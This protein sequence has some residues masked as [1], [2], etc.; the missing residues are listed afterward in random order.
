MAMQ[1]GGEGWGL[2]GPKSTA[3]APVLGIDMDQSLCWTIH[4][5]LKKTAVLEGNI[6]DR[7]I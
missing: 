2:H 1:S 6:S 7:F 4:L 3:D 5:S